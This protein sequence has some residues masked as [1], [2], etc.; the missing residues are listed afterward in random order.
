MRFKQLHTITHPLIRE[1]VTKLRDRATP[2]RE[3]RQLIAEI[4]ALMVFEMTQNLLTRPVTVETPLGKRAKGVKLA[5]RIALVPIWR[6]GLGML[7]GVHRLIPS[8]GVGHIGIYRDEVTLQPVEYFCKLPPNI[9][10]AQTIVMDPMLATGGSA[11][12]AVSLCKRAGAKHISFLCLLAAPDG[13]ERF[14][15]AHPS[16]PVFTAALDD[17]LNSRGYILP[18]LG[19]AGDRLYGTEK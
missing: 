12:H 10:E 18:G 15:A 8:A 3:F 7:E 2:N 1:K 11:A 9:A 13:C 19:D 14:F 5:R 6:A 4:S 17:G 16:T